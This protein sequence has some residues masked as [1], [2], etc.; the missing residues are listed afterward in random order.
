[1]NLRP[2]NEVSLAFHDTMGFTS[3][4][5]QDTEGGAKTVVMLART[6]GDR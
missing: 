1:M 5:E 4:G 6:L 3:V 2:R